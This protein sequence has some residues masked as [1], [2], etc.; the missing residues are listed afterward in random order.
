MTSF[1]DL[2]WF[3]TAEVSMPRWHFD[4]VAVLGD[5]AH[6]LDPHLGVGATMA[7]R[8]GAALSL[9]LRDARDVNAALAEWEDQRRAQIAPYARMSRVWSRLDHWRLA[10]LRRAS[11][12]LLARS[13]SGMRRRLLR[14]MSGR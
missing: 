4:R 3:A 5:A 2:T 14:Y 12:R 9:A 8:D 11:F 6:A 1:G 10:G 7:L 13:G